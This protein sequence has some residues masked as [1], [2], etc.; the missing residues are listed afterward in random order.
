M[1]DS[2]QITNNPQKSNKNKIKILCYNSYNKQ[3]FL[4]NNNLVS[5]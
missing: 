1:F 4:Y 3:M 2:K 5:Y